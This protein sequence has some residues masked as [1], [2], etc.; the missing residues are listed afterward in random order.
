[1]L[2]GKDLLA[3]VKSMPGKTKQEIAIAAG[4]KNKSGKPQLVKY[5]EAFIE[6]QGLEIGGSSAKRGKPSS[7]VLRPQKTGLVVV[8]RTW[9][10]EIGIGIDDEIEIAIDRDSPEAKIVGPQIILHKRVAKS[11]A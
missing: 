4:Y 2:T 3:L 11:V 10:E 1:M 7:S 8:G 6:A 9:W 5:Y